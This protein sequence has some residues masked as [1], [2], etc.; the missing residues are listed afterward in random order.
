MYMYMQVRENSS[1]VDSTMMV[2]RLECHGGSIN[3]RS[4]VFSDNS[5]HQVLAD[6]VMSPFNMF[7]V[8]FLTK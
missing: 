8:A 1:I 2:H 6:A 4:M 3:L 7:R 5:Q